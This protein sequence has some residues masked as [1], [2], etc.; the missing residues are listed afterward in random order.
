MCYLMTM[1]WIDKS[2]F[3]AKPPVTSWPVEHWE[4]IPLVARCN[5]ETD[6]EDVSDR[7]QTSDLDLS[8]MPT[9]Y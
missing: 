6:C 1:I 3:S 4:C 8:G 9:Y 2:K 5:E 7:N